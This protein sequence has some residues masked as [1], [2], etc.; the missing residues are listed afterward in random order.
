LVHHSVERLKESSSGVIELP[1]NVTL[2]LKLENLVYPMS[3]F[4]YLQR[5]KIVITIIYNKF[6]N[7][8]KLNREAK[9]NSKF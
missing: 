1:Q 4:G 8:I 3:E 5:K 2:D 9:L 6:K 7:N